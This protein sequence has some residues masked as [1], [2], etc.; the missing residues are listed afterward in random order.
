MQHG[1]ESCLAWNPE[2]VGDVKHCGV[3]KVQNGQ[4]GC[5]GKEVND[6]VHEGIRLEEK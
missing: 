2:T 6:L 5:V 1:H 3:K 4:P